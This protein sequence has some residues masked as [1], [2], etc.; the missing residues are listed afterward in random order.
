MGGVRFLPPFSKMWSLN[1]IDGVLYS[2]TSQD[3][4]GGRSGVWA[5]DPESAG[6]TVRVLYTAAS[7]S[8]SFC[9]GGVWGRAEVGADAAG[10]LYVATG[11]APFNPGAGQWGS[12]VLKLA[13]KSLDVNGWFVPKNRDFVDKLDLDLGNTSNVVFTWRNRVLTAVGGKEGVIY[14]M[15]T[16]ALGGARP[17]DDHVDVTPFLERETQPQKHGIWGGISSWSEPSG[18]V[19]L[20]VPTYGPTTPAEAGHFAMKYGDDPNGSVQAFTVEADANGPPFLQPQWRSID[21]KMPDPVAIANGMVFALATGEDATQATV[22]LI[23][24]VSGDLVAAFSTRANASGCTREGVPVSMPSTRRPVDSC[25]R[26]ATRSLT[27]RISRCRRSRRGTCSSPRMR[28]TCTHSASGPIAASIPTRP[29]HRHCRRHARRPP[30]RQVRSRDQAHAW[31]R[32]PRGH[33]LPSTVL[34]VIARRARDSSRRTHP[35]CTTWPGS[36]RAPPRAS[37]RRFATES[38]AGCRHSDRS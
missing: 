21:M 23:T 32:R 26:A 8:K 12:S 24:D 13:A 29:R 19:W 2:T 20:Y 14:L 22:D 5:I 10:H 25:G 36:R 33:S 37:R 16:A 27:G 11:D 1:Y 4:N 30:Q 17:P 38:R 3:C 6:R 9:G 31:G 34:S 18:R 15:D 7:C 28:V 35:T